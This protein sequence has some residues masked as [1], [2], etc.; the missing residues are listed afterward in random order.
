MKRTCHFPGWISL[1][2]GLQI[3]KPLFVKGGQ[4][5]MPSVMTKNRQTRIQ[6]QVMMTKMM[7][8]IQI[9]MGTCKI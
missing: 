7:R 2:N 9:L 5:K 3:S 1:K 6:N 8:M 4:Q